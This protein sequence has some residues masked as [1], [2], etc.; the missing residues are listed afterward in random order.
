MLLYLI[1]CLNKNVKENFLPIGNTFF[2]LSQE[3]LL[4]FKNVHTILPVQ[5]GFLPTHRE[6]I[7][8]SQ[9]NRFVENLLLISRVIQRYP[10]VKSTK[11]C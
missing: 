4:L 11:Q 5:I 9:Q 2:S 8:W 7:E 3:V 10:I 6:I 1:S